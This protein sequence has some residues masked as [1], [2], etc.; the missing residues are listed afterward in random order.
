MQALVASLVFVLASCTLFAQTVPAAEETEPAVRMW[1]PME[2]DCLRSAEDYWCFVGARVREDFNPVRVYFILDGRQVPGS[3]RPDETYGTYVIMEP[4]SNVSSGPHV[5]K[6]VAISRGGQRAFSAPV[7]FFVDKYPVITILSP[8]AGADVWRSI[9]LVADVSDDFGLRTVSINRQTFVKPPYEME[10]SLGLPELL[11]DVQYSEFISF[12]PDQEKTW[13]G[14]S[15]ATVHAEDECEPAGSGP[16]SASP[17]IHI[18]RLFY[19]DSAPPTFDWWSFFHYRYPDFRFQNADN[20]K[21]AIAPDIYSTAWSVVFSTDPVFQTTLFSSPSLNGRLVLQ[22]RPSPEEWLAI[23]GT[24]KDR[25]NEDL[26]IYFRIMEGEGVVL[27]QDYFVLSRAE[28]MMASGFIV[29]SKGN[30]FPC[31]ERLDHNISYVTEVSDNTDFMGALVYSYTHIFRDA[32]YGPVSPSYK[33]GPPNFPLEMA[34]AWDKTCDL[35]ERYVKL[36]VRFR[37]K[38][39]L[40]RETVTQVYPWPYNEACSRRR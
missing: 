15:G 4:F 32:R 14:K 38:D 22:W 18:K 35:Q 34:M 33:C 23:L 7:G 29:D 1:Y 28:P 25:P 40:G 16:V 20:T 13:I 21:T 37:A 10:I 11:T 27:W 5:L 26:P 8:K 19:P 39:A 9:H 31:G 24:G 12:D 3:T 30:K 17:S 36:F 6:A 2:G